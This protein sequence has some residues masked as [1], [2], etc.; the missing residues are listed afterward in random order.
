MPQL[1]KK[2]KAAVLRWISRKRTTSG[3]VQDT[4]RS[5]ALPTNTVP[6]EISQPDN[7]TED[8]YFSSDETPGPSSCYPT[9]DSDIASVSFPASFVEDT[10]LAEDRFHANNV[11]E[12]PVMDLDILPLPQLPLDDTFM[13]DWL[14]GKEEEARNDQSMSI[15]YAE[16]N[17][18][19]ATTSR[20][21]PLRGI[22]DGSF[23][24]ALNFSIESVLHSPLL[25]A[26]NEEKQS[27]R[28]SPLPSV[29]GEDVDDEHCSVRSETGKQAVHVMKSLLKCRCRIVV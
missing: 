8:R 4:I 9:D 14:I 27:M 26:S 22:D 15:T 23:M 11:A 24:E 19:Y 2:R 12:L 3:S 5:S 25:A 28:V 17:E 20:V 21:E 7:K 10:I 16:A 6:G 13:T 29:P 1:T 18:S